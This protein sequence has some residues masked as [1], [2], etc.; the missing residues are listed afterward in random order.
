[1]RG[2]LGTDAQA[3]LAITFQVFMLL[4]AF[5]VGLGSAMSA[6]VGNAL[7]KMTQQGQKTD[8]NTGP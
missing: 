6:L 8:R 2:L 1:M 4:I 3:G 5:G 7:G